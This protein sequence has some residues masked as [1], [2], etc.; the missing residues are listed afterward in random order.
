LHTS[1]IRPAVQTLLGREERLRSA[2]YVTLSDVRWTPGPS[3]PEGTV[4]QEKAVAAVDKK[5]GKRVAAE[6]GR[7][8]VR[9]IRAVLTYFS[10]VG[11]FLIVQH[12]VYERGIA[13]EMPVEL[14]IDPRVSHH[15]TV[16]VV[17]DRRIFAVLFKDGVLVDG[18]ILW[19]LSLELVDEVRVQRANEFQRVCQIQFA[20]GSGTCLEPLGTPAKELAA[21]LGKT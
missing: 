1:G 9:L 11:I 5:Y 10:I 13:T 14:W 18:R 3:G 6:W 8:L 12:E 19:E 20:D 2:S 16:L 7:F 4:V 21:A 15:G 17:T